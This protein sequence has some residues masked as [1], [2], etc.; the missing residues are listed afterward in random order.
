MNRA[1]VH[2]RNFLLHLQERVDYDGSVL[3]KEPADERPTR[4]HLDQLHNEYVI[5]QQLT[6]VAGVRPVYAKEGT[7]SQPVLFMEYIQGQSLAELIRANSLDLA[8]KLRLA[9]NIAIVLGRI[10]EKQVMHKDMS[11]SNI[12]VANKDEPGS[13]GGVYLI[14]FGTASV[15]QQE[16]VSQLAADDTLVGTLAYISP[17]QTG[18]MNRSVDY[19]TDLYSLGV[20]LYELFIGQLPFDSND[21]LEL[22]HDHIARQPRPPHEIEP[23]IPGPVSVI[24]L[25]LL[26]KNAEARYQTAQGL[27]AD[28]ES[29]LDQWQRKGRIE[30]FQLGRDDFIGRL[31]IPQKLYGRQA[32]IKHLQNI[33]ERAF[34]AQSQLLLV[35][36]Y[37]GVGKTSLVQEIQKDVIA[38]QGI[39]IEGKFDQL[40]RTLPYS[41][42]EQ[43]FTQ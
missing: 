14:D 17:E 22:I 41:A 35:A 30:P 25:K 27:Q 13:Q 4:S 20:I 23:A 32:E 19:R 24:V 3:L 9:I 5:T 39:Y 21:V 36:G 11:S 29:C 40:Q 33:L 18:R 12:L 10:H 6:D 31:Q 2:C 28:L 42:W 37:S 26:A 43:A 15:T 7:E 34:T 16:R 38:K 1:A 8:E